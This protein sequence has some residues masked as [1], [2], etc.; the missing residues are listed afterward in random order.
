MTFEQLQELWNEFRD[1][2]QQD[3]GTELVSFQDMLSVYAYQLHGKAGHYPFI[4]VLKQVTPGERQAKGLLGYFKKETGCSAVALTGLMRPVFNGWYS[5]ITDQ[6]ERDRIVQAGEKLYQRYKNIQEGREVEIP[7]QENASREKIGLEGLKK[8]EENRKPSEPAPGKEAVNQKQEKQVPEK[9]A[10]QVQEK[11]AKQAPEKAANQI[12]EKAVKQAQEK[13]AKQIQEKAANQVPE[14]QVPVQEP[15]PLDPS[16]RSILEAFDAIRETGVS[17]FGTRHDS[18]FDAVWDAVS[19]YETAAY[20]ASLDKKEIAPEIGE[21]LYNA[22]RDYLT[23]HLKSKRGVQSL[24]GQGTPDGRLRKQAIV[25]MLEKMEHGEGLTE[26]HR[27][28]DKYAEAQTDIRKKLPLNFDQLKRSLAK[29]SKLSRVPLAQRAYAEL[30]QKKANLKRKKQN[31]AAEFQAMSLQDREKVRRQ[32]SGQEFYKD[33]SNFMNQYPDVLRQAMRNRLNSNNISTLLDMKKQFGQDNEVLKKYLE[34]RIR[35]LQIIDRTADRALQNLQNRKTEEPEVIR[36]EDGSISAIR[37]KNV[38]QPMM[39]KTFNGCWSVALASLLKYRGVDLDQ[40]TL[41]AFRPAR[42]CAYAN[43]DIPNSITSYTDLIQKVMPNAAVN[44]VE[45]YQQNIDGVKWTDEEKL[46]QKEQAKQKLKTSLLYA[47][48]ADKGPVAFLCGSHYRTV[49]GF[50]ER[51]INGVKT[52]CVTLCDPLRAEP[53]TLTLDELTEQSYKSGKLLTAQDYTGQLVTQWMGEG[54]SFTMQWLKDLTDSKGNLLPDQKLASKG[55]TYDENGMLHTNAKAINNNAST[56]DY[57]AVSW[58]LNADVD[59]RSY[60]P[61]RM[62]LLQK[63]KQKEAAGNAEREKIQIL[64][65]E[66]NRMAVNHG[67]QKTNQQ[68]EKQ[69][70][71]IQPGPKH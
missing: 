5:S 53:M 52:E 57:K 27:A 54:Y 30:E 21:K 37:I 33:Y 51:E 32:H 12:P 66:N 47:L 71:L 38:E 39:Q 3:F 60:L 61:A 17:S 2:Y 7:V 44:E 43:R 10:K 19:E 64:P 55:V 18:E 14:Q 56:D 36:K 41:R 50:E 31:E 35:N 25:S 63:N 16:R 1:R 68:P 9:A 28:A 13:A 11:A 49:L 45:V 15:D 23:L 48:D 26:F 65:G 42:D 67:N 46:A 40:T 62:S 20:K 22:C 8:A 29:K 6:K 34:H 69:P 59:V 58:A 70:E 4:Q 24:D